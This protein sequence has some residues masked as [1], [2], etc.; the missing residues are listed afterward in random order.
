MG[1]PTFPTS[2]PVSRR[3]RLLALVTGLAAA[4]VLV[5]LR[6]RIARATSPITKVAIEINGAMDDW[7]PVLANPLQTTRDGDGSSAA[8]V[9]NCSAYSTDRDCPLSGGAGNDLQ[10]FAWTYDD[11]A[12]YLYIERFATGQLNTPVDFFFVADVNRDGRLK[13]HL[14][15]PGLPDDII[16]H[17][18]WMPNEVPY[19][20]DVELADYVPLDASLGDPIVC[21]T[22]S[23]GKAPL[24]YVDG[25]KLPGN[26][27]T[28]RA[29]PTCAGAADV[30]KLHAEMK[31]PWAAFGPGVT[32]DT[33]F[34]WHV[35]SSN[36]IW[37][38]GAVDNIGA[39]DGKLGSFIERGVSLGPD[40]SGAA[41]AGGT[42][43]YFHTIVNDGNDTDFFNFSAT[44]A[45]GAR[46]ELWDGST[47]LGADN[48]GDGVWDVV[49]AN[50]DA[51]TDGRPDV[52][53]PAGS[54]KEL[55]LDLTLP[56]RS[57]SD[58]TRLTATSGNATTVAATATDSTYVGAPAFAP[59]H[60]E[61]YVVVTQT[62]RFEE[63]LLNG[64]ALPDTFQLT[65]AGC[66]GYQIDLARDDAGDVG[67]VVATQP[68]GSGT[69]SQ[70]LADPSADADDDAA[71]LPDLGSTAAGG[72]KTFWILVTP[73]TGMPLGSTCAL[74]VTAHSNETG[75]TAAATHTVT[76]SGAVT[77]T[78]DY[79]GAARA[80][81]A[82]GASVFLPVILRNASATARAFSLASVQTPVTGALA[83]RIWSDPDGD[84]S[85]NDG[86]IIT[87]SATLAPF[88]G[89]QH[90]LV[91]LRAGTAAVAETLHATTTATALDD[92][93]VFGSE[94]AEALVGHVAV[95]RDTLTWTARTSSRPARR[96]TPR[97]VGSPPARRQRTASTGRTRRPSSRPPRSSPR[98]MAPPRRRTPFQRAPCAARG[99]RGSSGPPSRRWRPSTSS[100]TEP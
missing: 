48:E 93:S 11:D 92:S 49:N 68:S 46:V 66:S 82:S 67:S 8:I 35:A 63:T 62:L 60:Q 43:I 14:E 33:P 87:A 5:T 1:R 16:V 89:S 76:V 37:L 88:G 13:G 31:V 91:E 97:R 26:S 84:G 96:S 74:I 42:A 32:K 23:C 41:L 2:R 10:T 73:P 55:R 81:V 19:G 78:P 54:S 61:G 80:R 18:H 52:T 90:L 95:Y 3:T 70:P 40:R 15:L 25:Y 38:I 22:T 27:S 59:D 58:V 9:A 100:S 50:T 20:V 36:N 17:A 57:G 98:R 51:A 99:K 39:P 7:A 30:D 34:N 47:L 24:G 65:A 21:D 4:A 64:Q 83:P 12:V 94:I 75:A 79:Q 56:N 85:A 6:D 53:L 69:W 45:M 72:T 29:C 44:D 77:L 86:A 71:H 28:A